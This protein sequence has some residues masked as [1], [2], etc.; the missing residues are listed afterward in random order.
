MLTFRIPAP[1]SMLSINLLGAFGLLGLV[2]SIGGLSGN[3][4]W[5]G[6]LGGAVCVALSVIAATHAGAAENEAPHARPRAVS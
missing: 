4:W 2:V 3:W 6:L 5:S 1:S